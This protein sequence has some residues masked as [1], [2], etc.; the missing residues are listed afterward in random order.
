VKPKLDQ[1][2]I[3]NELVRPENGPKNS[4]Q[5]FHQKLIGIMKYSPFIVGEKKEEL[6]EEV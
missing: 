3:S 6:K 2:R 4:L 5:E 1:I